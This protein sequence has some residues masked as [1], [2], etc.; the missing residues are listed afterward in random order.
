MDKN[1]DKYNRNQKLF[2]EE[3]NFQLIQDEKIVEIKNEKEKY[4]SI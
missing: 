2:I 1:F 4:E 3:Y